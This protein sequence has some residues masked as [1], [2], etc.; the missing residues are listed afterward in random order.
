[1]RF[2]RCPRTPYLVTDRKRVAARRWQQ[3]QRDAAPLLAE[4]VAEQQPSI[5]QVMRDRVRLW[6]STEQSDR[7]WRARQWRSA[8]RGLDAHDPTTRRVLLD[9][10]NRHRWMTADPMYLLDM[11]HRFATGRLLIEDGMVSPA[12]VTIPIGE[13]LDIDGRPKP[14][15]TRWLG[16]R[17][18]RGSDQHAR[19]SRIPSSRG[20]AKES[21]AVPTRASNRIMNA[22]L[23][24]PLSLADF[25]AWEERQ[26]QR[27]EFDGIRPVAMTGGTLEHDRIQ[28]NLLTELNNRLRGKPCRVHGNSLKIQ[29]MGSI[30]CPDAFVTCGPIKRGSTIILEP[31]VIFEVLSKSTAHT[32]R[33]TKNREYS[34]TA[35]VRRYIMLEQSGIEGMMFARA[36]NDV[37]WVGRILDAEE[38]IQ[39]PE[40]GIELPLASLYA[41]ID[42]DNLDASDRDEA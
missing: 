21:P 29:V 12:S 9:Y 26:E 27:Y 35:S 4:L 16:R 15:S 23:Q 22:A 28:V 18:E 24:K 1:M 30:R 8:R 17:T 38:I 41:N 13:A 2:K 31:V 42:F 6:T 7:D 36:N 37:D 34:A 14:V 32:D 25:L 39:L 20:S 19:G 33:M 40:L 10:W 3:R 11:L 5:D